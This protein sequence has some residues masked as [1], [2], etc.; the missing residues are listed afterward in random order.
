M[1]LSPNDYRR[2]GI[3]GIMSDIRFYRN[4]E[5]TQEKTIGHYSP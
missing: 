4:I 2:I 1:K 5:V 3:K